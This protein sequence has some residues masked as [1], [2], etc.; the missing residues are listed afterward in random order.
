M[1]SKALY[2]GISEKFLI[3]LFVMSMLLTKDIKAADFP[4]YSLLLLLTAFGWAAAEIL[5]RHGITGVF[6]P[7]RYRTDLPV[8]L[9]IFYELAVIICKLFR[10][11]DEGGID[12]AGNAEVLAFAAL[13]LLISSGAAFSQRYYDLI[14]YGG[15]LF[16]TVFLYSHV[17]G[18]PFPEYGSLVWKDKGAAASCFLLICMVGV[19]QYCTCKDRLRS[20]FYFAISAIGFLALFLNCNIVSFWLMTAYFMAIPVLLRPTA[21]LVRK[22]MQMFFLFGLMLSNMSLLTAYTQIFATELPFSL[23]HSIYLDLLLAVGGILFFYYWEK[24]PEG[25]DMER[26]V[27]RKM[28]RV[29]KTALT[30]V[31]ILFAGIVFGGDRWTA[32][33]EKVPETAWKSFAM[34]L[35]EA[36][37]Q[38]ESGFYVCFREA[39]VIPGIFVIIFLTLLLNRL[40]K[41]YGMDKPLTG[42]LTLIAAVFMIQMFFCKPAANTLTIY[43]VLLLFAAFYKEEKNRMVSVRIRGETLRKQRDGIE[44]KAL[45]YRWKER[46]GF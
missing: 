35:V 37:K 4:I 3:F 5:L 25:I 20:G 44:E 18:M 19:Y 43:Y 26:L 33:G 27:L 23:E 21:Q 30:I 16:T 39:G 13:Y 40:R 31:V 2:T 46:Q 1:L 6:L 45:H 8:F 14:L 11:P 32:L 34:P 15:L 29:Y 28:R 38:T 12:F 36:V 24:V 17:T 7:I 42:S 10:N 41:N 9:V 22:S